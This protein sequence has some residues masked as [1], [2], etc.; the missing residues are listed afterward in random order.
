[1]TDDSVGWPAYVMLLLGTASYVCLMFTWFAL[2]AYLPV[3]IEDVGLTS[4]EAGLLAGAVPLTYVPIAL[5]SGLVIDRVG[6]FRAVGVGVLLFGVAQLGRAAAG[7]FP[8]LLAW[9]LV[10]G[11]GGTGIT[12]GL[13]KLVSELFPAT[14][15]GTMSS[16]YLLGSYAG[17]ASAFSL[18]RPVFGPA[19]GGW[20]A[21]FRANGLVVLG[22]LVVWV[23]ATVVVGRRTVRPG[24]DGS[25]S[26]FDPGTIVADVRA[27]VSNRGMQLLVVVGAM[28]LLITHGLQGWLPTVLE[29]RGLTPAVAGSVASVFVLGQAAGA[30]SIPAA[31]DRLRARR[32]MVMLCGVL[33]L[34]GVAALVTSGTAVVRS[35]VAVAAVGFGIGGLAPLVR[36]I[37]VELDGVGPGLTA[38][39]VG[40]VFMVG[41]MGGFLGPF[42]VGSL[43]DLTG[44]YAVGLSVLGAGGLLVV[45]A[46]YALP[47][48]Q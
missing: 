3:I 2:P 43:H 44:T 45:A 10:L 21:L 27:V 6:S 30:L 42:V 5:A 18:G 24:D 36:A 46:G 15:S 20:R 29:E 19:L 14:R 41:E 17:T 13:P 4:T 37:P 9:T 35:S 8:T 39:A 48:V 22:F 34:G 11:V 7:G 12:F 33:A 31:S 16:V 26:D 40:L 28:Y 38:T 1:M 47:E 23:A 32:P 25:A